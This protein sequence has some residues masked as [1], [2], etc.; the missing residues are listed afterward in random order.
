MSNTY[1]NAFFAMNTRCN[2]VFPELDQNQ[3]DQVFHSIKSEV[4]RI[5]EK[6]SRFIPESPLSYANKTAA[7]KPVVVDQELFNILTICNEYWKLTEGAFDITL[8]PLMNYW[9]KES[10]SEKSSDR[11]DEIFSSVGMQHVQLKKEH[12]TVTFDS[13]Y[14]ELDLGGFGKGYALEKIKIILSDNG[15]ENAF[16]SFGE[17]S[18]LTSG[19]HPA[20]DCWK[21]SI[22]NYLYPGSSIHQFRINDGSMSTSA[23]F[24]LNDNGKIINH[25]HVIDPKTGSPVDHCISVSVCATSPAIAEIL[26]TAFLVSDDE[27]IAKSMEQLDELK[28]IK[29][30]YSS[31]EARV[32]KF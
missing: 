12:R 16:I 32:K 20:G 6:L 30:D 3:A 11:L 29:V 24:Y 15:I 23:N 4:T 7:K 13:E 14:I 9:S 19:H 8:R 10:E 1:H 31:N 22:N 28:V 2:V 25:R 5:E 27:I 18:I 21:V 26:S 17:S